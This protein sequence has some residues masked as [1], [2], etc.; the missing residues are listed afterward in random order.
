MRRRNNNIMLGMGLLLGSLTML[1]LGLLLCENPFTS[2]D[3]G[4]KALL[5]LLFISGM[6]GSYMYIASSKN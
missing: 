5:I 1:T 6:G 3:M 4:Q 2:F